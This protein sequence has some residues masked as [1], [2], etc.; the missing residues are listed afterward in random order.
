VGRALCAI[1][2]PGLIPEWNHPV[3]TGQSAEARDDLPDHL[4]EIVQPDRWARGDDSAYWRCSCGAGAGG[5]WYP[6][7]VEAQKAA[8]RHIR[9]SEHHL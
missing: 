2:S 4:V 8:D 9:R 5:R 6:S 3:M 7:A 1:R